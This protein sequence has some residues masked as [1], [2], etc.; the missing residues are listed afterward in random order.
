MVD[1]TPEH[2]QEGLWAGEVDAFVD[3]S[4]GADDPYCEGAIDV[5]VDP[6]GA[7]EGTAGCTLMWGPYAGEQLFGTLDGLIEEDLYTL[8]L[9]LEAE[10]RH[11]EDTVFEGEVRDPFEMQSDAWYE[12]SGGT[13]RE[14]SIEL[15]L[16]R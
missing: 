10:E 11:F 15:V 9:R 1:L 16:F 4:A 5:E 7:L 8:E 14:A 2:P 13:G 3:F 12:G 6:F